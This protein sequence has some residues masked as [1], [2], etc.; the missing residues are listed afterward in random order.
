[1]RTKIRSWHVAILALAFAG[2]ALAQLPKDGLVG[3]WPLDTSTVSGKDVKDVV[4]GNNGV[5][6]GTVKSVAGKVQQA[7]EFDG[8]AGIE[9]A[10]TAALNF[11]AVK[12][13]SVA[14]WVN[15][16]SADPVKG[17]VAGCC[18][19]I[20]A[21]RGAEGWALR[22]DGRNPDKEMEFIVNSAGWVGDG[23]FGVKKLAPNTWHH[24]AAVYG[25]KLMTVYLNGAVGMEQE[26]PGG[27]PKS[28]GPATEIGKAADGGFI[29]KIDEVVIYNRALSAAEV[30]QVFQAVGSATA[31]EP[32][33]KAATAWA[34][35]KSTAR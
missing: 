24:L 20:V 27:S 8:D 28:K 5:V 15:A 4:G 2:S 21:Q 14:A 32:S 1:V 7:L 18:G 10:G 23:G 30:K 34:E 35:I 6:V 31:V 12:G 16:A 3:H 26:S 17:V 19:S 9:I 29:G 33:G 22:Y 11:S 25:E 13:F